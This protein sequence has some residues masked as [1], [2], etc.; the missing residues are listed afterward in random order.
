LMVQLDRG[1]DQNTDHRQPRGGILDLRCHDR[2][3]SIARRARALQSGWRR[4][5]ATAR[6]DSRDVQFNDRPR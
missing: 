4:S 2:C 5:L 6:R 1:D 3:Q